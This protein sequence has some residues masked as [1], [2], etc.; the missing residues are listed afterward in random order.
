MY[1]EFYGFERLP[2][3]LLPNP[4]F[5]YRS[6]KHENAL[7]HLEYGV[8][9]RAGFIVITGEIGT[10][11]TTLLR[12]LVRSLDK[13]LPMALLTQT[14]LHPE[15]LL[16]TLCQEFS[17]P[18]EN[19]GKPEMIELFGTFLV[20]QYRQGKYVI[21]ILDE[22]QNLP[23]ETLEEIRMLSNLDA[24]NECLLQIILVGQ[25]PL[26]TKLQGRGLWQ[27]YQRVEVSYHLEPLDLQ[28][29]KDYIR[30]RLATA[31]RADTELFDDIAME[32]IFEYSRGVPRLINA[33][34]HGCLVCG[35]ADSQKKIHHDLVE[36]VLKDRVRRGLFPQVDSLENQ[37]KVAML[38]EPSNGG[39][40]VLSYNHLT[41][42]L[43]RLIE[44]SECSMKTFE[45]VA[46]NLAAIPSEA[47]L[48][49]LNERL[50]EERRAREALEHKLARAE[51]ALSHTREA[52]SQNIHENSGHDGLGTGPDHVKSEPPSDLY[53]YRRHHSHREEHSPAAAKQQFRQI[54]LLNQTAREI[55]GKLKGLFSQ[56]L[57]DFVKRDR[58]SFLAI[59]R[60]IKNFYLILTILGFMAAGVAFWFSGVSEPVA[61][62]PVSGRRASAT[63]GSTMWL[64]DAIETITAGNTN[65]AH[66]IPDTANQESQ[67]SDAEISI[68][69]SHTDHWSKGPVVAESQISSPETKPDSSTPG[70]QVS[71]LERRA[72]TYVSLPQLAKIRSRPDLS[73]PVLQRI[74]QGTRLQVVAQEEDWLQLELKEGRI[75]WIHN[76]LLRQEK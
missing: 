60:R 69:P 74:S 57:M 40:D 5:F 1:E 9:E 12:Y 36:T 76:S 72:E 68:S 23:L 62:A 66:I 30:Y 46:A 53:S 55:I 49:A 51:D 14:R 17:L 6:Q 56:Y 21:L 25:P 2:F 54:K 58:S 43:E 19:K 22:A 24:D 15:E 73:A 27:L 31:G 48:I 13:A 65:L 10:G 8:F 26:R 39:V 52:L 16:R 32:A 33:V 38:A 35:F 59:P 64:L 44:I 11:K 63:P 71:S 67:F 3:Q 4:D 28:E 41:A 18:H 45:K 47:N 75:G 70:T 37:E 61:Q 20:E 50:A 7:T 42:Q 29:L 34:C